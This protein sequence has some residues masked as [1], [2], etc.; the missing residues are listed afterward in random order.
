MNQGIKESAKLNCGAMKEQFLKYYTDL[1]TDVAYKHKNEEIWQT[2][3]Q[4]EQGIMKDDLQPALLKTKNG[5]STGEDGI[6]SELYKYADDKFHSRLL[7]FINNIYKN[8]QIPNE[9][10]RST[11]EL[12]CNDIILCD[13]SSTASN[14]PWYQLIPHKARVFLPCLIRHT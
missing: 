11:V 12:C 14:I 2:E 10:K 5:K 13:T 9:W 1:W 8:K 4:D 6:N 3:N 7:K